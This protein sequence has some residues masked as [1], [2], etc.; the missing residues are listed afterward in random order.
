MRAPL[1]PIGLTGLAL[2][3]WLGAHAAAGAIGY[4]LR[5][6]A[7]DHDR[8]NTPIC[9]LLT[10]AEQQANLNPKLLAEARSVVLADKQGQRIP[11]QLAAPGLLSADA[12]RP[13]LVAKELHFVLPELAC[14]QSM[15][16]TATLSDQADDQGGFAWKHEPKQFA[17]LSCQGRPVLRYMCRP[18]DDSS[19]QAREETYKVYHHLY[20]PRG[21]RFLTKGPGGLYT[22]HRGLFYGFNRTSYEGAGRVD[23]WHCGTQAYQLHE[24]FLAEEAGPVM[25]RHLL[26]IGWHGPGDKLFAEEKRELAVYGVPGGHLIQFVS[27]LTSKVPSLRLDGDPQ[28]AGF[29]FRAAQEV[30]EGDQKL[31]Y[32][33]RPDGKGEPGETRNW[34]AGKPDPRTVNLP[35]NAMSFVIDGRR[36]TAVYLDHPQNPKEARYSER[37]YGRFG[38]YF[39][40]EFQE[41]KPLLVRYRLFVQ[42]GEITSER[43][44]ELSADWVDPPVVHVR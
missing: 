12:D 14:G 16:L 34:A 20:D 27:Q 31:T 10:E 42:E 11:A 19:P 18:V 28:H 36:Y 41:D 37:T 32:Y 3:W 30:A 29:H 4:T 43:A 33:L 25:G 21:T 2:C 8:T 39:E 13:G 15:E 44:A 17:E 1:A 23:I 6:E 5:I 9:V 35:W 22:H 38:S 7:G 26:A 40:Y 24:A